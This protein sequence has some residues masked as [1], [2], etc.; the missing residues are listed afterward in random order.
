MTPPLARTS[1]LTH[2][3]DLHMTPPPLT[4]GPSSCTNPLPYTSTRLTHGLSSYT[5]LLLHIGELNACANL[6]PCTTTLPH[7]HTLTHPHTHT[8]TH[9][10]THTPT[11][12]HTTSIRQ[13]IHFLTRRFKAPDDALLSFLGAS[14][15]AGSPRSSARRRPGATESTNVMRRMIR[16][17]HTH[18]TMMVIRGA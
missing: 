3:N 18:T 15:A 2:P 5:P 13:L 7:T 11:H 17:A 4:H 10:H 12:S 14:Q 16:D 6:T 8:P 9:S 1:S